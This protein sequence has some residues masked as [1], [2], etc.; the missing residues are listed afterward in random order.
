MSVL[1][2]EINI[3][4]K[5]SRQGPINDIRSFDSWFI[6][7]ISSADIFVSLVCLETICMYV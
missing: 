6:I 1:L 5:H 7:H 4:N 2:T 3:T